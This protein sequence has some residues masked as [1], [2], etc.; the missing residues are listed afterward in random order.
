MTYTV[1]CAP[2]Y[3]KLERLQAVS[4]APRTHLGPIYQPAAAQLMH[5][6][7]NSCL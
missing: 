4:G 6:N 7:A 3:T 2:K 1:A 5:C